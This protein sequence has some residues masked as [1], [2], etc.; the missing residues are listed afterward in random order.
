MI[1]YF[2]MQTF[3]V[4]IAYVI[5]QAP[6]PIPAKVAE[7][8][9]SEGKNVQPYAQK[10]KNISSKTGR[11][12]APANQN[13][14][15]AKVENPADKIDVRLTEP[16]TVNPDNVYRAL[17][18]LLVVIGAGGVCI[19]V[20]S[21]GAINK[22]IGV[23]QQQVSTMEDQVGVTQSQ[24]SVFMAKERT[25]LAVE[26]I[27]LTLVAEDEI[28]HI[29]YNLRVFGSSHAIIHSSGV[30]SV[31]SLTDETHIHYDRSYRITP[32]P[33]IISRE[34]E[35]RFLTNLW[36]YVFDMR[37][38]L[39]ELVINGNAFIDTYGFIKYEDIFNKKRELRWCYRWHV[40]SRNL[41]R[42]YHNEWVFAGPPDANGDFEISDSE[43]EE[44]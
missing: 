4:L 6:V 25:R 13:A 44:T 31:L 37:D 30:R 26:M 43:N 23:M 24:L 42:P 29:Y 5:L 3:L 8:S 1:K 40:R 27:D 38:E 41:I 2:G 14:E 39:M 36:T 15:T 35:S 28:V 19:A 22:Q 33:Q 32:L 7:G 21:L 9:A 20:R 16:I 34:T 10:V 17:T 18:L 12:Q 11:E